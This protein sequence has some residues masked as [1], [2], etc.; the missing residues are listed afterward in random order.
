MRVLTANIWA[1][2]G[3]YAVREPLLRQ[4]LA[5]LAADVVALQEVAAGG[6]G[7]NQAAELLGPLGYEVAYEYREGDN[8][9]DPG[10]AV[11]SRH[12]IVDRRL[13]E[14]PHGGA[15]V[16]TRIQ[17]PEGTFW[18]CSAAP[19]AWLPGQEG[20][21]EDDVLAL[22]EALTG[23]AAGDDLPP[24]LAGDFNAT[25]D[26]AGI[27]FLCG[28]Q[29][30]RGRDTA[31]YDAWA[32]AG[33]GGPGHTWTS[34]NL[35]VAPFAA[36]VFAQP[37]HHRRIDYVFVAAPTRWRPRVVVRSCRVVLTGT[38]QAAPSDHFGVLA[39]LDLD[40]IALG[41]GRGLETWPATEATLWP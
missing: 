26:S 28:L 13:I 15:A 18:F 36:A 35:Y 2:S 37:T 24:I 20:Q 7:G 33:D 22:D 38:T 4:E 40:G 16:A 23:I 19:S 14:L 21:R 11:A 39:D 29:S 34:D 17:A 12:P 10:I 31:W 32:L 27:R 41:D 30:L 3:P 5:L 1:R 25:P 8:V 9:G 6:A